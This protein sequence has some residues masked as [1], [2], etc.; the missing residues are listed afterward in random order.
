M[1]EKVKLPNIFSRINSLGNDDKQSSTV[2]ESSIYNIYLEYPQNRE[3]MAKKFINDN[4]DDLAEILTVLPLK[5]SD[6]YI[7]IDDSGSQLPVY[8]T[9]PYGGESSSTLSYVDDGRHEIYF[10]LDDV[11]GL[12]HEVCHVYDYDNFEQ[13]KHTELFK[14]ITMQSRKALSLVNLNT[15]KHDSD[16]ITYQTSDNEI[17]ARILNQQ[18]CRT[19]E[20]NIFADQ[21]K[22]VLVDI[23]LD[24]LY[25]NNKVFRDNVNK[26]IS[27]IP[28]LDTWNTIKRTNIINTKFVNQEEYDD[29]VE[30]IIK[31]DDDLSNSESLLL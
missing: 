12:F 2:H 23:A 20:P 9:K 6:V 21:L 7:F 26:F 15:F 17:L 3:Y 28:E 27:E 13:Y 10:S 24:T 19:H 29:F 16:R 30:A 31:I 8:N 18:Y 1:V 5:N 4:I 22:P 25:Q 11:S 14:K